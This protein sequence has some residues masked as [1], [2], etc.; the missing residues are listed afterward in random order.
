M[1]PRL[2]YL[3]VA[4]SALALIPNNKKSRTLHFYDVYND[5]ADRNPALLSRITPVEVRDALRTI[6]PIHKNNRKKQ[7][8]MKVNI[9]T[10]YNSLGDLNL[11]L[12][13][14]KHI[15]RINK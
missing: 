10:A 2:L 4:Q 6:F 9:E 12:L 8:K 11:T 7:K 3:E 15:S 13:P 1:R 14:K 5:I